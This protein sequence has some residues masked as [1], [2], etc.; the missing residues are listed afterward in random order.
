MDRDASANPMDKRRAPPAFTGRALGV[1]EQDYSYAPWLLIFRVME[2]L[3]DLLCSTS[4]PLARRK[5]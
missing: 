5:V 1:G 2:R 4:T 3:P